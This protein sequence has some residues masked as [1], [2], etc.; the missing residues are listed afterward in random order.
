MYM[1]RKP[2]EIEVLEIFLREINSVKKLDVSKSYL[3]K[4]VLVF[5]YQLSV[6]KFPY[7]LNVLN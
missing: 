7:F 1:E 6:W 4:N 2:W 3:K 5:K